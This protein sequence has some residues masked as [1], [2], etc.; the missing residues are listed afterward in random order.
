MSCYFIEMLFSL[1]LIRRKIE[2]KRRKDRGE[3]VLT[4]PFFSHLLFCFLFEK[5]GKI[6]ETTVTFS[7]Q[8]L[9]FVVPCGF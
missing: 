7:C 9:A 3:I 4:S 8:V 6:C 1:F 5:K 2:K